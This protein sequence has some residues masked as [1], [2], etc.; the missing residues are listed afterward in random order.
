[1]NKFKTKAGKF[2]VSALKRE[3]L[4]GQT[5]LVECPG[6]AHNPD[7]GGMI[8]NCGLCAPRWGKIEIPVEHKTIH[9]W[10]LF[11]LSHTP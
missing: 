8:D 11:R 7:V 6:E 5:H 1:M 4:S 3:C 2:K 9:D 10:R